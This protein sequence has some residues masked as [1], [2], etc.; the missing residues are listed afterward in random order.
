MTSAAT[1][2]RRMKGMILNYGG[3][4]CE[5]TLEEGPTGSPLFGELLKILAV[6]E[7]AEAALGVR[8]IGKI[9]CAQREERRRTRGVRDEVGGIEIGDRA[10][11]R[12]VIGIERAGE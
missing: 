12:S 1:A 2:T 5:R 4:G 8:T 6:A 3:P 7:R 10:P 9:A 11:E